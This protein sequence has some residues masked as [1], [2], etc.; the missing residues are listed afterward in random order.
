MNF[1]NWTEAARR[2]RAGVP[3]RRYGW[4]DR[5]L[6]YKAGNLW[7]IRPHTTVEGVSLGVSS[8]IVQSFDFN[9]EEFLSDDWTEAPP[10]EN[11]ACTRP[12]QPAFIPP[13]IHFSAIEHEGN[14]RLT[15][16]LG[17]SSL[18]GAYWLRFRVNGSLI[19]TREATDSGT[20]RIDVPRTEALV[21]EC[22]LDV[23]SALPLPPWLS[24]R[25]ARVTLSAPPPL[26]DQLLV[27]FTI[28]GQAGYTR[29]LTRI[30]STVWEWYFGSDTEDGTFGENN[31]AGRRI[32]IN[33]VGGNSNIG[34]EWEDTGITTQT[35]AGSAKTGGPVGY[36]PDCSGRA[37]FDPGGDPIFGDLI[38]YT[39]ISVNA[40]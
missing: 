24:Q 37:V 7:F 34:F 28:L 36:Y 16:S 25:R 22:Q 3:V 17:S 32:I 20:I 2:A 26:P 11:N 31:V 10:E 8:R 30:S 21:Y 33:V 14:I 27:N 29:K 40:V 5:W 39:A 4:T 38:T 6:A 19:A 13:G 1:F 35:G 12:A 9:K 18:S 23:E 15:A